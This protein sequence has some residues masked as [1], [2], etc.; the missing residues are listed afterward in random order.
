MKNR[1]VGLGLTRPQAAGLPA[2]A[3]FGLNPVMHPI[4]P[5]SRRLL[6][7]FVLSVMVVAAWPALAAKPNKE[8]ARALKREPAAADP[9][10]KPK[11][12]DL[13][14]EARERK[15]GAD[16]QARL[17]SRVRAQMEIAEDDEWAVIAERIGKVDE[18]RRAAAPGGAGPRA[19]AAGERIKRPAGNSERE[20]LRTAVTDK[21]PEAE[22]KARLLRARE[23][24]QQ[25]EARLAAAQAELRAVLTVR[26]EAV[27]VLAGFLPP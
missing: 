3:N 14:A 8:E 17:L 18:L 24:L 23:L 2:V 19:A 10:A 5:S 11:N 16:P 4:G 13:P 22:I 27:A 7:L 9:A 12:R 25:Q 21:L 15:A 1:R 20:A 26:Q 6:L